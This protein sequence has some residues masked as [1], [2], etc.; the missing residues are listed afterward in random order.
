MLATLKRGTIKIETVLLIDAMNISQKTLPIYANHKAIH[1]FQFDIQAAQLE[2]DSAQT[3]NGFPR[4]KGELVTAAPEPLNIN[5]R[6]HNQAGIP[7]IEG[8]S[9]IK[10]GER[11]FIFTQ[12]HALGIEAYAHVSAAERLTISKRIWTR[13]AYAT[14]VFGL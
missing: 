2:I 7:I 6:I 1:R 3:V 10:A 11:K 9:S 13:S 5:L 8:Q 14:L 12:F 4:L